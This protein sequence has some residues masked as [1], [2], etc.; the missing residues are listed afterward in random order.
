MKQ[1]TYLGFKFIPSG[2]KHLGIENLINKAKKS[3]FILQ[4]FL[5]KSEGKTANTYSN[6]TDTTLSQLYFMLAK[7]GGNPKTNII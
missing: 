7:A 5:Y 3:W 1:Y 2:K 6:L 4:R